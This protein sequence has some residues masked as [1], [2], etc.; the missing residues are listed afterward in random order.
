M[1]KI[2]PYILPGIIGICSLVSLTNNLDFSNIPKLIVSLLGI[3]AI[4]LIFSK[5]GKASLIIK[6][7]IIAQIPHITSKSSQLLDNGL[8]LTQTINYWD[9]S[10]VFNFTLGLTLNSTEI[11]VNF[12][13][14]LF[15]GFYR[16]LKA[17]NFIGKKVQIDAGLERENRL[18]NI[19]PLNGEFI[20]TIKMDDKSI[21]MI[22]ELNRPL[23][24]DGTDYHNILLYPKEDDVF[25]IN[26]RQLAY[27]RLINP[28]NPIGNLNNIKN[29]Y[30]F[31]DYVGIKVSN[32]SDGEHI[33]DY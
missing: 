25:K 26:I 7:W 31:I 5:D 8:T 15:L 22:A 10:Q 17:S 4:A 21:W 29:E 20:D 27:L 24:Y 18:G 11:E 6:I 23:K 33:L 30:Q 19:F 2:K 14:F 28:E 32:A 12:V 1:D 9:T 13:P 16:L 3:V